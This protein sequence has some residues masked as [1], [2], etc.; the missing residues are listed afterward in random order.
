[1]IVTFPSLQALWLF[2]ADGDDQYLLIDDLD[3]GC[4]DKLHHREWSWEVEELVDS[5][6]KNTN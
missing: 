6:F 3:V 5:K 4:C 2:F 1:M